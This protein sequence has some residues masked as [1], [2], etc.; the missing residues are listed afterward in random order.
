MRRLQRETFGG[1]T[2]S[3]GAIIVQGPGD[4]P[5]LEASEAERLAMLEERGFDA[6]RAWSDVATNPEANELGA[7]LYREMVR[8][9]VNDPEL[10]EALS[11]RGFP[12]G[13]KRP[14]ID[15]NY[16][17]TFNRD[18]VTLVDL[19][20]G[21]IERITE[22]G[23]QT[24]QAPLRARRD[25]LRHR[26]R[27]DD[28]RAGAHRHPRARRSRAARRMGGWPA[29]VPRSPDRRLPE[30][31]HGVRAR[32]VRP[33]SPTWWC[34]ASSTSSGSARA[35]RTCAS[36]GSP[37]SSRRRGAGRVGRA[38]Q[39]RRRKARCAPRRPA[40]PG[41]SAPTSPGSRACSCR[42]SAGCRRYIEKLDAIASRGY[43]GTR[44][45]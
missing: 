5:I 14:V 2:G 35:S 20:R 39:R 6:S 45:R 41:T 34:A 23:I 27:R 15:S 40:T 37:R 32:A 17:E 25:R 33:C 7:E 1:V 21:G 24:A 36:T 44:M 13:C 42:T 43:E 29:H 28:R 31:L 4:K 16:F 9:T 26:L 12:I 22:T 8:R 19:R 11:P 18:N 30:P 38:R 10:A 3:T